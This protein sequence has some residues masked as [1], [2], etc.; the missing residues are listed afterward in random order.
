MVRHLPHSHAQ[1]AG[2]YHVD[3]QF[4]RSLLGS[5]TRFGSQAMRLEATTKPTHGMKATPTVRGAFVEE[6]RASGRGGA[7]LVGRM[8]D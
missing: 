3:D 7:C 2:T 5:G 4:E 8:I 1:F 6:A